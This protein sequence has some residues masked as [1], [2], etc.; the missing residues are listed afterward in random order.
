MP[1]IPGSLSKHYYSILNWAFCVKK[2]HFFI[3]KKH[4]SQKKLLKRNSKNAWNCL[5][6]DWILIIT[7]LFFSWIFSSLLFFLSLFFAD[8]SHYDFC[9]YVCYLL[10]LMASLKLHRKFLREISIEDLHPLDLD[11]ELI[12]TICQVFQI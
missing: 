8:R 2:L 12:V 11:L 7:K 5:L 6:V 1:L 9:I 4:L 10:R 3:P